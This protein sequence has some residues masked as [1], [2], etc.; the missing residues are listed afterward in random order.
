GMGR[1]AAGILVRVSKG[2]ALGEVDEVGHV[3]P[4]T[5]I[6]LL[7]PVADRDRMLWLAEKAAELNVASWSPVMWHRS[8]SVS[9]RGEGQ[10]FRGKIRARMVS[11]MLQSRS[12]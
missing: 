3:D 2:Q 4:A 7:I 6:H 8:K 5:P 12:A 10:T 1:T 9:P 11:A